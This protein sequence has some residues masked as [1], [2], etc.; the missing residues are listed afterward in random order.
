MKDEFVEYGVHITSS[1]RCVLT[2]IWWQFGLR[3]KAIST[4]AE[5]RIYSLW[6]NKTYNVVHAHIYNV[7]ISSCVSGAYMNCKQF[8][9]YIYISESY[10]FCIKSI[11]VVVF[12]CCWTFQMYMNMQISR[13]VNM[14][15]DVYSYQQPRTQ[16]TIELRFC[17]EFRIN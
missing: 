15:A 13:C 3:A 7:A 8:A 9:N 10:L 1:Y 5:A 12:V 6:D 17:C 11:I 2:W 4:K 14:W 16:T